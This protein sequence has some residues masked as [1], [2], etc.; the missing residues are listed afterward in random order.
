[1]VNKPIP[2]GRSSRASSA[3]NSPAFFVVLDHLHGQGQ[4]E[5]TIRDIQPETI[6]ISL[7]VRN[8]AP[9]KQAD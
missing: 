8:A 2:P 9:R 4:I 6:E 5:S 7:P 1:V 3:R